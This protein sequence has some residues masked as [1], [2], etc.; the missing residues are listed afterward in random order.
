MTLNATDKEKCPFELIDLGI[1]F[2]SKKEHFNAASAFGEA[3]EVLWKKSKKAAEDERIS[4]LFRTKCQEYLYRA[5]SLFIEALEKEEI[6]TYKATIPPGMKDLSKEEKKKR[7]L[8]FKRIYL[9]LDDDS[10]FLEE[11]SK[12]KQELKLMGIEERL[13]TLNHSVNK[14]NDMEERLR[15]LGVF[16]PPVEDTKQELITISKEEEMRR[17][18]SCAKDEVEL[19]NRKDTTIKDKLENLGVYCLPSSV[20]DDLSIEFD[21][22]SDDEEIKIN[23]MLEEERADIEKNNQV[24]CSENVE[25]ES[26]IENPR[27]Q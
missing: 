15:D 10:T 9:S 5:R 18:M 8:T 25:S 14:S 20:E 17:I 3:A 22:S 2:E 13:A 16:V 26:S 27:D 24:E 1:S 23:S 11:G 21:S 6:T 7:M 12:E 19:Y 4:E